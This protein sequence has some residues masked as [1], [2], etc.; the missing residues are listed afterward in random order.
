MG[1]EELR[2]SG[3]L[4][5]LAESKL[6]MG[7]TTTFE[8]QFDL[9]K[10]LTPG[11]KAYLERFAETRHMLWNESMLPSIPDPIRE[12]AEL[13]L[14][15]FC[16]YFTGITDYSISLTHYSCNGRPAY[17]PALVN[18]NP[19]PAGV[20]GLW[21]K[22]APN[23]QGTAIKWNGAEKFY[24]YVEWLQFLIQHFLSPW[25]YALN[26]SVKW[27]GERRTDKGTIEVKANDLIVTE[28]EEEIL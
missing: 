6:T 16:I 14:G 12:A 15:L 1:I 25:G 4:Q 7:Y 19:T 13:P 24:D 3:N 18:Y 17:H 9:D 11:H 23:E 2:K 10:P 28:D 5:P 26:G 27:Q 21:C 8:G 22:W 20:P